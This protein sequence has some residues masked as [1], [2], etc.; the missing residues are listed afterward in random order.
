MVP[1]RSLKELIINK[2]FQIKQMYQHY[3]SNGL[4]AIVTDHATNISEMLTKKSTFPAKNLCETEPS[5]STYKNE[6]M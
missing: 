5:L 3:T 4:G 2:V 1:K 6:H